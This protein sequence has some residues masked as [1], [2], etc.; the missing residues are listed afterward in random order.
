MRSLITTLLLAN[1]VIG[2]L[3][4]P[5]VFVSVLVRNKAHTL[6][7]FL[8]L[9]E[10]LDYPKERIIVHIRSDMNEDSSLQILQSWVERM[11]EEKQYHDIITDFVECHAEDCNRL[12]SVA[13]TEERFEYIIGLRQKAL[14]LARFSLADFFFPIDAD[15]FLTNPETLNH[16]ITT[17]TA[18]SRLVLA[19]MLPSTGLYSNFWA[20]MTDSYYYART[21]EYRQILD[22]KKIGV[23]SVP[24][25]HSCLLA[26]LRLEES[27]LLAYSPSKV[28]EYPGPVD[29][30]IVFALSATLNN[31]QIFVDNTHYY[32]VIMLPLEEGQAL[33][34]DLPNLQ[35]TLLEATVKGPIIQV[36]P[37]LQ[38]F[39][40]SMPKKSKLGFDEIF[41]VNLERRPDRYE[42][43]K[44]NFDQLGID[45][46]WVPAMDGRKITEELLAE[47]GI[48]M[49]PEFSEPYHG[50]ALTYGEIGCFLSHYRLWQQI[51][52]EELDL[53]LIF[54]DDI[55][56]E[57][58]FI[59]KLEYLKSELFDLEGSWD[60]VFLG[61]KIL[62]NSEEPWLEGSEQLV[63]VDYTYWTLSYLLTL[64]GAKLLLAG[65]PLGKMVPVD[66]YL[67][68]MY[69]RHP[70]STWAQHFPSEK[71]RAL[72][73]HPLL[74]FPT[75]YTGE[76][77]YFSDT[78]D[79]S[80]ISESFSG[81]A[82]SESEGERELGSSEMEG[83]ETKGANSCDERLAECRDEL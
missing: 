14:E 67:P 32:G 79:A 69:G 56:F 73:V 62:H 57:P 8:S 46:K 63:K 52:E 66:E 83:G 36:L 47:T 81:A 76:Q 45:Y 37:D 23:H 65:E 3:K 82:D 9:L 21:E 38:Q 41:M 51:V 11:S 71:L 68:I 34:A 75:H 60:L 74:V 20:G 64:R 19:P 50:R 80:I 31:N 6:P 72:S 15:V 17:S 4:P 13:W 61:R 28:K 25:V 35:N 27:D 1:L 16:L 43:M 54:E 77:G 12:P 53:V 40:Q 49:L 59:S 22:R 5:S 33:S 29:D 55:K 58:Y 42:R 10:G 7:Y 30:M 2:G 48:K 44:Y 70:N 18:N 78:E 26:N 24:M 39:V